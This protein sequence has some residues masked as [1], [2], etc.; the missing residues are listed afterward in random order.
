M[1]RDLAYLIACADYAYLPHLRTPVADV[2]ALGALLREDYGYAVE[3]CIDPDVATLRA[4]FDLAL[5]RLVDGGERLLIYFAGHGYAR[6]GEL[7]L[8][9]YLLARDARPG[10]LSSWYAMEEMLAA[11]QALPVR[12]LLLVLD[13]CFGGVARFAGHHRGIGFAN[14]EPLYRQ[15]YDY[16]TQ[17]ASW[18]VLCSTAPQ[19]VALDFVGPAA[20]ATHSPFAYCLLRGLRGAADLLPDRLITAAELYSYLQQQVPALT[21]A[22]GQPQRVGFFPLP[23][24]QQGEYLFERPGFRVQDLT[25]RAYENPYQ[26]LR[27]YGAGD[28]QRFFGRGRATDALIAWQAAQPLTVVSGASGSGKSSLVRAGL[29]P[30]LRAAGRRVGIIEPGRR[31]LAALAAAT[32]GDVLVVDQCEQVVTQ[33]ATADGE[34]FMEQLLALPARGTAVVITVRIDFE[35]QLPLSVDARANWQQGRW[36]MPPFTTEELRELIVTPALR[37]GRFFEPPELVDRIIDEVVHYPG[38]LPL[39][40]FLLQQLFER[41]RDHPYRQLRATDYRAL[42]GVAGALRAAADRLAQSLTPSERGTLRHFMLR[43]V[44]VSGGE[45]AGRRVRRHDLRFGAAE[46][47][48]LARVIA[49][50]ESERLIQGGTDAEGYDYL[51]PSHDALVRNW[52]ML[53]TWI[54][55][56]GTEQLLLH[57]R[58]NQAAAD[59]FQRNEQPRYLWHANPHLTT[60]SDQTHDPVAPLVLNRNEASFVRRSRWHRRR[61]AWLQW[62][63]IAAVVIGLTLLSLFARRQQ[64]RA[65]AVTRTVQAQERRASVAARA[66]ELTAR[67]IDHYDR[68]DATEG[69]RLVDAACRLSANT[70]LLAVKT[71]RDMLARKP[72]RYYRT[73]RLR[74]HEHRLLSLALAPHGETLLSGSLDNTARLWDVQN[75]RLRAVL[76]GHAYE[77]TALALGAGYALTGSLDGTARL[78]DATTGRALRILTGHQTEVTAAAISPDGR[79]AL[80]GSGNMARLWELPGGRLLHRLHTYRGD[81]LAVAFSPDGRYMLTGG[82]DQTARLWDSHSGEQLLVLRGHAAAVS[83]VAFDPR[84][85]YLYTGGYDQLIIRWNA[86]TGREARRLPGHS[87]AVLTLYPAADGQTLLSAGA[88]HSARLWEATTGRQLQYFAGHSAP[89]KAVAFGADGRSVITASLD[90]TLRA[91]DRRG[92]RY[93]ERVGYHPSRINCLAITA[94]GHYGLSGGHDGTARLWDLRADTLIGLLSGHH[95]AVQAVALEPHGRYAITGGKDHTLRQWALPG[96]GLVRLLRGQ[97]TDV[98]AIALSPDGEVVFCGSD[99]E[100]VR[101]W[102]AKTGHE[103]AALHGHDWFVNALA[104]SA[105]GRYLLSGG[106][107][108]TAK[109]WDL[110]DGRAL[111]TLVGHTARITAV[112]LSPGGRYALTGSYDQT[113]RLWDTTNGTELARLQHGAPVNAVAF[114]PDGRYLLSGGDAG[115]TRLWDRANGLELQTMVGPAGVQAL[116]FLPPDGAWMLTGDE[117]GNMFRYWNGVV[118][119]AA[120]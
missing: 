66:A 56:L 99:E 11:V 89:V 53:Q 106:E 119:L 8:T 50:L 61:N 60:V 47:E 94:D 46:D 71:R 57:A 59:Y 79:Y 22:S 38:S 86:Q 98:N 10:Q 32:A 70:S 33:V 77:V 34:A 21:A 44:T 39:L 37:V 105:D 15:H 120:E 29:V 78:W 117:E 41:C 4:N 69:L 64:R 92:S 58:L 112:A 97:R 48:R 76:R 118:G 103:Q 90:A 108:Y 49:R 83:A 16:F 30:R 25:L 110:H 75:R 20:I 116:A 72:N 84:G 7:G 3:E 93:R 100:P 51:E 111:L 68:G 35:E 36:L 2:R 27:A 67:G 81:V 6:D 54:T 55:R 26:G 19:Q 85:E 1:P 23:P 74:G 14:D 52:P 45:V 73:L 17:H 43:L 13:C 82:A 115:M 87:G 62:G 5:P 114:S 42:G 28:A 96:R 18:Q 102:A 113:L 9:G 107:D 101:R 91:W 88:D 104:I 31:P 12:H 80:T 24:H 109:Y 40:S 95:G 65:E 63:S